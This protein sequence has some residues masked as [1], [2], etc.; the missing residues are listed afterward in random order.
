MAKDR[1]IILEGIVRDALKDYF[2]VEIFPD[3]REPNLSVPKVHV[4]AYPS[5]RIRCNKIKLVPGDRVTVAVS[6]YDFTKGRI[7]YRSN[8]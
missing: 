8:G 1:P 7:T 3:G 2:R 6:K 5:G 4:L